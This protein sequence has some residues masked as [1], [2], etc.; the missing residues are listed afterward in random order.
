MP[1]IEQMGIWA[2]RWVSG[3]LER[4]E[5]DEYL[6]MADVQ[7]RLRTDLLPS[8][9]VVLR[10]HFSGARRHPDW[11]IVVDSEVDLC[12]ADP[13]LEPD[14]YISTSIRIM[15]EIWLGQVA[16]AEVRRTNRLRVSG[17]RALDRSMHRWL[18]Y[19]VFADVNQ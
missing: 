11:W 16:L 5:L 8:P 14:L 2:T 18:G 10:F 17:Q 13:G 3:R 6:L 7:R 15:I 1:L 4:D 19:S 12:D 9:S